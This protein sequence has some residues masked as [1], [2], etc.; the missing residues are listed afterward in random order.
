MFTDRPAK[1]D[2]TL[3]RPEDRWGRRA[4]KDSVGTMMGFYCVSGTRITKEP[5]G[6]FYDGK[7]WTQTPY[8]PVHK[9]S[10]PPNFMLQPLN[11][12]EVYTIL[13]TTFE[14]DR[15]GPFFVTVK[16]DCDFKLTTK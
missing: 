15:H 2:I 6:I 8:M 10:T 9:I 3:S 11:E 16:A 12:G 5:T 7:P 13:P 14:P 1:V 4:V